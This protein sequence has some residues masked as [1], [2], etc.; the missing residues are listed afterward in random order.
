MVIL[1]NLILLKKSFAFRRIIAIILGISFVLS[2]PPFAI[3]PLFFVVLPSISYLIF[4]AIKIKEA[5]LIIICFMGAL[6][7]TGCYW[8]AYSSYYVLYSD[9]LSQLVLLGF[10]F[11]Y[12]S[13]FLPTFALIYYTKYLPSYLIIP[14]FI[15]AWGMLEV[16]KEIL[17]GGFPW[18]LPANIWENF[19]TILNSISYIGVIGLST[20][21]TILIFSI[22]ALIFSQLLKISVRQR[23]VYFSIVCVI[24]LLINSLG[25]MAKNSAIKKLSSLNVMLVQPNILQ[26]DKMNPSLWQNN[27]DKT[28]K[29]INQNMKIS[30]DKSNQLIILPEVAFNSSFDYKQDIFE[31]FFKTLPKNSTL[32]SGALRFDE[33]STYNSFYL[34][35]NINKGLKNNSEIF[36]Y[37]KV[38]LVPFGEYIPLSTLLPFI[39]S[40]VGLANLQAGNTQTIF[41][42]DNLNFGVLICFESLFTNE[43]L[44]NQKVDWIL[45]I[46]NEAW[47]DDSIE[48]EQN[49]SILRLRAIENGVFIIKVANSGYSAI[50]DPF[51]KI[52]YKSNL[53][54]AEVFQGKIDLYKKDVFFTF[55]IV[56]LILYLLAMNYFSLLLFLYINKCYKKKIY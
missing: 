12:T 5:M 35:E 52:V 32:L 37:D 6:V 16:L 21:T 1:N 33:Q 22:F 25:F 4:S 17:W 46:S 55:F 40:F 23:L 50:I 20:L 28:I 9:F 38:K 51:G 15:S 27:F 47:F 48:M 2:F 24:L 53:N 31:R 49:L 3:F 45:N 42:L 39:N 11:L 19:D 30:N 26:I 34:I 14:S 13:M 8:I 56:K 41:S 43:K 29:L 36:Y 44:S 18:F 54:K 10:I 7:L